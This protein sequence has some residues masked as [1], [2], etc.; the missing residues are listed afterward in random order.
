MKT[1]SALDL[2]KR[3]GGVLD[4]VAKRKEHVII[5]RANRPMAVLMPVDEYDA[6]VRKADRG[7]RLR[8][9]SA[10]LDAWRSQHREAT[11]DVNV[12]AAIREV[13]DGR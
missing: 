12:V 1:V 6:K 11:A 10:R 3:L 4:S 2:R 13:R 7:H 8:E 5:S 9:I